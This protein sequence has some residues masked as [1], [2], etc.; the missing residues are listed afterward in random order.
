MGTKKKKS[1]SEKVID[2]VN[3]VTKRRAKGKE[4]PRGGVAI[5]KGGAS[6]IKHVVVDSSNI[7]SAGYDPDLKILQIRFNGGGL[8]EYEDVPKKV[9]KKMIDAES[10]GKFFHTKIKPRYNFSR[11]ESKE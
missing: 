5:Q 4:G 7:Q 8:F 1:I 11:V 3:E 6:K 9:F 10:V 2:D